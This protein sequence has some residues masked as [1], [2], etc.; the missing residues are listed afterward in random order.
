MQCMNPD[1][2]PKT[3]KPTVKNNKTMRKIKKLN[4]YLMILKNFFQLK[5]RK[6]LIPK[7]YD[8]VNYHLNSNELQ[9]AI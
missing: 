1:L 8:S 6:C 4:H 7:N 5:K 2:D 9:K 3:K